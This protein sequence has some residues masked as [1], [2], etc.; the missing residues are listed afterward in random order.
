[1]GTVSWLFDE[2]EDAIER[3][4]SEPYDPISGLYEDAKSVTEAYYSEYASWHGRPIIFQMRHV[5]QRPPHLDLDHPQARTF[6]RSASEPIVIE[7]QICLPVFTCETYFASLYTLLH[8]LVCHAGRGVPELSNHHSVFS[9]GW[10]D[11]VA[12]YLFNDVASSSPY[13]G[14]GH[15]TAGWAIHRARYNAAHET[16][17]YAYEFAARAMGKR[18][19][20]GVN[21]WMDRN[22]FLRRSA[23][24]NAG[25]HPAERLDA[26]V[27]AVD[28]LLRSGVHGVELIARVRRL[29]SSLAK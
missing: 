16:T 7:L 21:L 27:V 17:T 3:Y 8:E 22:E 11:V 24:L 15:R 28:G 1:M 23:R 9:E 6:S 5:G 14:R 18:A 26:F 29:Y 20:E 13:S 2:F 19:A 12:A 10:M 25:A 4:K